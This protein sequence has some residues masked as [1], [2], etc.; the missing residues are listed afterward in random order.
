[1]FATKIFVLTLLLM[2]QKSGNQLLQKTAGCLITA[3]IIPVNEETSDR[4][5]T[6]YLDNYHTFGKNETRSV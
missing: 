3:N 4:T 5:G 2:L 1:K 6:I